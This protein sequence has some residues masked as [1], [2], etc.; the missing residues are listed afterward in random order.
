MVR[1]D[2]PAL[3][4]HRTEH[5]RLAGQVRF[6][7]DLRAQDASQVPPEG[8][9]NF[10]SEWIQKHIL[11]WDQAFFRFLEAHALVDG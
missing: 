6:I 3:A 4:L 11:V 10:L 1:A 2:F 5:E 8:V 7:R 9:G